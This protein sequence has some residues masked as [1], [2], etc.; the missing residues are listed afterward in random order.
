VEVFE[1][2]SDPIGAF[3]NAAREPKFAWTGPIVNENYWK[4][5]LLALLS[6]C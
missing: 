3:S 2:A 4:L 1:A 5:A 6:A